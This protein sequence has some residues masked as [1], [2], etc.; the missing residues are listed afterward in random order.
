MLEHHSYLLRVDEVKPEAALAFV[1]SLQTEEVN[2]VTLDNFGIGDVRTLTAQAFV[3]P[4][5]GDTQVIVVATSMI[6]VE[7]QQALLK[8][9]EEP[10]TSTVFVFCLPK[11]LYLLPTLLSRFF[12][13]ESIETAESLKENKALDEFCTLRMA[14]RIT[15]ITNRLSKKD[16][17]WVEEI[18]TGLLHKLVTDSKVMTP[19]KLNLLF[20][21]AEHLQTRGASNKLLLEEMALSL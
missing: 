5:V 3:R 21:V 6:T 15:E 1:S 2:Y 16:L 7:A 20:F 17:V 11:T 8:I 12:E 18:K 4:Q 14:D 9:L 19:E 10:P 13:V